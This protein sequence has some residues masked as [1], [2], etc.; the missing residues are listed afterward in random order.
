MRLVDPVKKELGKQI[1]GQERK[2][3]GIER[4]NIPRSSFPTITHVN[5]SARVLKI[6]ID[7]NPRYYKFISALKSKTGCSTIVDTS[8]HV[9]GDLIVCIPQDSYR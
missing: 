4:I 3:F 5:Y 1:S 2:L 8:F 7:T 9:R 6:S